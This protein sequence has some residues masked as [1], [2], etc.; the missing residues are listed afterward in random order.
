MAA[1]GSERRRAIAERELDQV[2]RPIERPDRDH[3]GLA[4]RDAGVDTDRAHRRAERQ[5]AELALAG[6]VPR[7]EPA[8]VAAR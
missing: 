6:E 7:G 8:I 1:L 2:Q 3:A 5:L 4:A